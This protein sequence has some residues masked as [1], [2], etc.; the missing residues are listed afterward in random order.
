M[1]K[2]DLIDA[3]GDM[4]DKYVTEAEE[5]R[6]SNVDK[7]NASDTDRLHTRSR[8]TFRRWVPVAAGLCV[9]V[10]GGFVW[11]MQDNFQADKMSA[12]ATAEEE[13]AND[14]NAA[15]SASQDV[16]SGAAANKDQSSAES[17]SI[18]YREIF[19]SYANPVAE[20]D[21]TLDAG[22]AYF[23]FKTANNMPE[24][25]FDTS[26][27][28]EQSMEVYCKEDGA[29]ENINMNL[30][31]PDVEKYL[32]I[33]VSE[34]GNYFSCYEQD[35]GEGVEHLGTM[36]YGFDNSAYSDAISLD[37]YFTLADGAAYHMSSSGLDYAELGTIMDSVIQQG[38]DPE[39]FDY[40]KAVKK[41]MENSTISIADA[42]KK[43]AFAGEI[44]DVMKVSDMTFEESG[45]NYFISYE[46]D[47]VINEEYDVYY[48]NPD[49][50]YITLSFLTDQS[51]YQEDEIP[52][53]QLTKEAVAAYGN[54]SD[55]AGNNWY[56]F[57]ISCEKYEISVTAN[58]TEEELWEY[59]SQLP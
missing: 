29:R 37:V 46:N 44:P 47:Q 54:E 1:K 50:D 58:C 28:T 16:E 55:S 10:I 23:A 24:L 12:T 11:S 17:A 56:S 57:S 39:T 27:Y 42:N 49:Y 22:G 4:D 36:V 52:R 35:L 48:S 59:L 3:I 15:G 25:P 38:I 32:N 21:Y 40:T 43:S 31:N 9:L 30:Y 13:A 2:E 7:K 41:E 34:S 45:S 19:K 53:A 51:I 33:T 26:I 8:R 5:Y 6:K 18:D 20:M 14:M